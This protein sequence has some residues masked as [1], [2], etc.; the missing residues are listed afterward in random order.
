M[1]SVDEANNF[2]NCVMNRYRNDTIMRADATL[3]LI[4]IPFMAVGFGYGIISYTENDMR[5]EEYLSSVSMMLIWF[6]LLIMVFLT[7]RRLEDHSNRDRVWRDILIHYAKEKGC[8]TAELRKL[9]R[10]CHKK[11]ST[12]VIY[13]ASIILALYFILFV[14]TVCYPKVIYYEFGLHLNMYFLV[15]AGAV[16]NFLMFILVYTYSMK[17]PYAHESSQVR[18]VKELRY[19]MYQKGMDIPEME[20]SVRH[21][22]L[23][24]H[25]FLFMITGGLYAIYLIIMVYR[26]TNNHLYNQWSYEI[27]LMKAIIKI[28]GGKGIKAAKDKKQLKKEAKMNAI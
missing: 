6:I 8:S 7:Y 17:Y 2:I 22:W 9:D 13:P 27:R 12:A 10:Q 1:S 14:L 21:T 5:I 26:S 15:V 25:I 11:E 16:F 18:F 20:P 3:L 23:I 4:A 19:V 28:E 24:I